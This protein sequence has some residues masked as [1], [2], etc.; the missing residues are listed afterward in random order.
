MTAKEI[1]ES[2]DLSQLPKEAADKFR[3]VEK[4]TKGFTIES[5]KVNTFMRGAYKKIKESKP[6]ALKNLKV[7]EK[8][9]KKE[10]KKGK[11]TEVVENLE[12]KV[13]GTKKVSKKTPTP[14]KP[15]RKGETAMERAK[16]IR[17]KDSSGKLEPWKDALARAQK[18]LKAE[19]AK[20]KSDADKAISTTSKAL[21]T[22]ENMIQNDPKLK[23]YP[24]TY[25]KQSKRIDA[26]KDA[27]IKAKPAG[28]RVSKKGHKNQYGESKGGRVYW[29]N[30]DNRS[31]RYA[32]NFPNKVFLEMGG[33]TDDLGFPTGH[34][35][36]VVEVSPDGTKNLIKST[37]DYMTALMS[38]AVTRGRKTN[39]NNR[40]VIVDKE[41]KKVIHEAFEAGGEITI[42]PTQLINNPD[43]LVGTTTMTE[44]FEAGG[45]TAY[46]EGGE[47]FVTPYPLTNAGSGDYVAGGGN[48]LNQTMDENK[49]YYERVLN[50]FIDYGRFDDDFKGSRFENKPKEAVSKFLSR[51][52]SFS[53][54]QD[55][56]NAAKYFL[57]VLDD[58][59]LRNDLFRAF[60]KS[61]KFRAFLK[62]E[63][64]FEKELETANDYAQAAHKFRT[65]KN[66]ADG[67]KLPK[68]IKYY[69]VNEIKEYRLKNGDKIDPSQTF[70][71][72]GLY[73]S[74]TKTMK[75]KEEEFQQ[76][77]QFKKGGATN[78]KGEKINW[79]EDYIYI[80]RYEIEEVVLDE[81]N[82]SSRVIKGDYVVSGL[83]LP[84]SDRTKQ[85]EKE[86]KARMA[87]GGQVSLGMKKDLEF[88]EDIRVKT[89][90][91]EVKQGILLKYG[92]VE[93]E[94]AKKYEKESGYKFKEDKSIAG[95]I[96]VKN[97]K[98]LSQG[99]EDGDKYFFFF[100]TTQPDRV[101]II[102]AFDGD[103]LSAT[104]ADNKRAYLSLKLF[105][106]DL[107]LETSGTKMAK[108]GYVAVGEKDGFWTIISTPTTKEKAKELL[109]MTTLPKGEKGKIVS[110][111][112]AMSH[113]NVL[114]K[115]YLESGG[116]IVAADPSAAM[117][118]LNQTYGYESVYAKGGNLAG[119]LTT[120]AN[121]SAIRLKRFD[122]KIADLSDDLENTKD[123][124]GETQ[125]FLRD[126]YG[127]EITYQDRLE[128]KYAKGG[129]TPKA[130]IQK[131]AN[132]LWDRKGYDL[133]YLE[134]LSDK[135]LKSL[136]DTEFFYEDEFFEKG[137]RLGFEGLAKKVAK[138][139][140]GKPVKA[141]YQKEYGKTYSKEEAMEVGRKVAAKVYG[142][143]QAK[144]E[145][146]GQITQPYSLINSGSA[147]YVAGSNTMSNMFKKGGSIPEGY[148]QMPDGSIMADS[149]HMAKGGEMSKSQNFEVD[150]YGWK[151]G[152]DRKVP[153]YSKS[154]TTNHQMQLDEL[155][156]TLQNDL[157]N[158]KSL[159][160][161]EI[162]FVGDDPEKDFRYMG[163]LN[164]LDNTGDWVFRQGR[165]RTNFAKGGSLDGHG[166]KSGDVIMSQEGY[167]TKILDKDGKPLFVNLQDGYRGREKPLP[168]A[169]GGAVSAMKIPDIA[170]K[171]GKTTA[172]VFAQLQVG[173]KHEM[174]HTNDPKKARKIALDHLSKDL[175]YYTKLNKLGL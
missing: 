51:M 59:Y 54:T 129:V 57:L 9:T 136:W 77:L 149:A 144:M 79:K 117:E 61:E 4:A 141:K 103:K 173:E 75:P 147:D 135:E 109:D 66:F 122:D 81:V 64:D 164:D 172:D 50:S 62:S 74:A 42:T 134:K 97:N 93:P 27:K 47:V 159:S 155:I 12:Y 86:M 127:K 80:P 58:T 120:K 128:Y 157:R 156:S 98:A 37:T 126:I 46:Q 171:F 145:M 165:V 3:K 112:E 106:L 23:G 18:E 100:N 96:D 119:L 94:D 130:H 35:F 151:I 92:F 29:E 33:E 20:A 17:K 114:G 107:R 101:V 123:T 2:I 11:E 84:K 24:R 1:F 32:P 8:I 44:L 39:K 53:K 87:K 52:E 124:I 83:Y 166:L 132:D 102:D 28:K 88:F 26:N 108:G 63:K 110:V 55:K 131:L 116:T 65:G 10:V 152:S 68:N 76:K 146:G 78:W 16:K 148:H 161:A 113:K 71:D 167:L 56:N 170:K 36:L 168:F 133:T 25:G 143:Q 150:F 22:L 13:K 140:E 90:N 160:R 67:G 43:A 163:S 91:S 40:V 142:Q 85:L 121:T 154:Y 99:I 95:V 125:E 7:E 169:K 137:G 138:R 175:D 158:D 48:V 15:K 41:D 21:K 38:S 45:V 105:L 72:S 162:Y 5:E 89:L 139:Y 111:D 30:R 60:L 118:D 70:V 104:R 73:V 115:E 174:E 19:A 82:H 69:G 153:A 49:A 34:T 31:D 14:S 6:T